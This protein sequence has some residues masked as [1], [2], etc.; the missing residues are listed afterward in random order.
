MS[1][2]VFGEILWDVY[3]DNKVIGGAPFNFSA[4]LSSLGIKSYLVSAVGED[5]LG[6]ETL[7]CVSVKNVDGTY[8]KL[9]EKPTG[10]CN[11][12][13]NDAKIPSYTLVEEVAYDYIS[14]S[15][16]DISCI[17]LSDSKSLY[18][19]T[20]AMRS[21]ISENTAKKL[22]SSCKW[23]NIFFDVNIRQHFYCREIIEYGLNVCNILKFSREEAYI[24]SET[25]LSEYD[26]TEASLRELCNDLARRY[27]IEYILLTLDKDGAAVYIRENDEFVFSEKTDCKVVSTVGAG[28]SF[29]AAY[30][31]AYLKGESVEKCLSDAI[32]L[33]GYVVGHV[34]AVPVYS[35]ELL[36]QLNRQTVE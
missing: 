14:V 23:D 21:K 35:K 18:I 28:D 29:F 22:V 32:V 2:Y 12:T 36:Q 30:I 1:V 13:L 26:G 11:V 27:N 19:G 17:N 24:F 6:R 7:E 34:E 10:V 33:S 15:D 25:G 16:E 5:D 9:S 8:V 4:H 20:L 31:N 3:P